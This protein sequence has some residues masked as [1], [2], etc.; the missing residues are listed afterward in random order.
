MFDSQAQQRHVTACR[1]QAF[2]VAALQQLTRLRLSVS[3]WSWTPADLQSLLAL[4]S[5][6]ELDLCLYCEREHDF[7]SVTVP[8]SCRLSVAVSEGQAQSHLLRQLQSLRMAVLGVDSPAFSADDELAL[9]ACHQG[10]HVYTNHRQ[11]RSCLRRHSLNGCHCLLGTCQH[12]IAQD[13]AAHVASLSCRCY[14]VSAFAEGSITEHSFCQCMMAFHA[15]AREGTAASMAATACLA[16]ASSSLL[17]TRLH[18]LPA[19]H[20]AAICFPPSPSQSQACVNAWLPE[21]AQLPRWPPLPAWHT[22]GA[23]QAILPTKYE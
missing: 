7:S 16:H 10:D 22:P 5:L 19:C 23:P 6:R 11:P 12:F 8:A 20:A 18:T 1:Q 3:N 13:Q 17:K 9:S 15:H 14:L 2:E 21:K 4:P